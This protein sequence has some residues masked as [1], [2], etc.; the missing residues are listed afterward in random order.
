MKKQNVEELSGSS[1]DWNNI[2]GWA[3][4]SIQSGLQDLLEAEVTELLGRLKS[5]RRK[6]VDGIPGYRNGY[7]KPRKLTMS[8]GTVTVRRP[9]V[10]GLEKQFES[11]ILPLFV[12][13]TQEVSD[14][15]P[16]LYLHGLAEGDFDMALRG[17]LGEEAALSARTVAR[18][19]EKWK[20]EFE[21]WA[22]RPL[23]DLEVT[24]MW[25]DGVY[26]K[27]GLEKEK[28]ALLVAIGA[29]SDGSKVVLAVQSGHRESIESWSAMLRSLRDRGMPTPRLVIGDGHLGIWGG[30][31]NVYPAAGEQR[32]WNH[33]ILNVV[34]KLP[35][36]SQP[37]AL[38]MLKK[39][40]YSETEKVAEKAKAGFQNWCTD[41]GFD[42][43]AKVLDED[44]DR[45]IA[46]YRFPKDHWKHLRTSNPVE[47]PFAALRL[48][49]NAAK[50]FKK[51]ENA[52]A[53]IWKMLLISEK[54]FQ[55]LNSAELVR[56]VWGG[57]R[58]NDGR[59]I[60]EEDS[61]VAA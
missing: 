27:A 56:V 2:E 5:E 13:R 21:A 44:W 58:Y 36:K 54:R 39:L 40:P 30:L 25:V 35:K 19:K 43:A 55:K 57:A 42:R 50:R 28:A 52:T 15:I 53:V 7:G 26:V 10:R 51:V 14:L 11:R 17:L 22:S 3:K 48:R 41:R 29:L 38:E 47:S 4:I 49:T 8:C 9:R 18:L 46:F 24:Y 60:C 23:D 6:P 59:L 31:R 20:A 34:D 45:M 33:R 32:C 37:A 12:R 61:R 1:I 16:E